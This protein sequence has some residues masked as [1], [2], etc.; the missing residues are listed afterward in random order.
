LDDGIFVQ[1]GELCDPNTIYILISFKK[2]PTFK[3]NVQLNTPDMNSWLRTLV[4]LEY[5]VNCK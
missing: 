5:F 1:V 3:H 2:S 4:W